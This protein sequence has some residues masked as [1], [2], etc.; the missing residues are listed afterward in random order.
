MVFLLVVQI[1]HQDF[2]QY[3]TI[4]LR[5]DSI[6]KDSGFRNVV[7]TLPPDFDYLGLQFVECF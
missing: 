3:A 7:D 1:P 6:F 4:I 2:T 5:G